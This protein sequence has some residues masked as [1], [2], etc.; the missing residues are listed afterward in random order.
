MA[1]GQPLDQ[2][3]E[4]RLGGL[5]LVA[6][7]L[8]VLDRSRTFESKAPSCSRPYSLSFSAMFDLPESSLTRTRRSL[9]TVAGSMCS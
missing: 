3:D 2:E 1:A 6:L 5:E 7:V 9:P 8:Q 4:R